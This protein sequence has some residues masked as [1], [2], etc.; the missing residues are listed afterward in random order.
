MNNMKKS[1][2]TTLVIGDPHVEPNTDLR[3]FVALSNFIYENRPTNIVQIGDFFTFDSISSHNASK[4]LTLEGQRFK[5]ELDAGIEAYN[6]LANGIRRVYRSDVRAKRKRTIRRMLWVEGN[7]EE[8]VRR[9]L[10]LNPQ[11]EGML[12]YRHHIPLEKDGWEVVPYRNYGF[13]YGIGFT[14]VPMN[15]NNNPIGSKHAVKNCIKDHHHHVVYG[16]N[17]KLIHESDGILTTGGYIRNTA[18]S[19][20]CFFE[21]SPEYAMGSQGERDWWRGVVLLHHLD[22]EGG[23]DIETVAMSRLL[24]EYL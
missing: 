24:G 19:V 10:E 16:H 14:H 12:D 11:M 22:M 9:Y 8:R 4:R 20:G 15:G 1:N 13:I 5:Q 23:F 6:L 2:I 21:N 17:H 18:T 3:R 7:H